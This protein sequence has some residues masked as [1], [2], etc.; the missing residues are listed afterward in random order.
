MVHPE[1]QTILEV[2]AGTVCR[3]EYAGQ[4]YK[5]KIVESIAIA[6]IIIAIAIYSV[7]CTFIVSTVMHIR[8]HIYIGNIT[9]VSR[10]Q[11]FIEKQLEKDI[12]NTNH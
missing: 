11:K 9:D 2:T 8:M 6:N 10:A 3:V 7:T 12:V 4:F 1:D 5:A